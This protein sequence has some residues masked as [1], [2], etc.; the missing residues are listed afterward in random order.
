[1]KGLISFHDSTCEM[2]KTKC[3]FPIKLVLSVQKH[4]NESISEDETG[5]LK[6][7]KMMIFCV[8]GLMV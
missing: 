1:M 7:K 8:D 6:K 5:Q 3:A 4:V 2:I